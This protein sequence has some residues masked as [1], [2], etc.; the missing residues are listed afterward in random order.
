MI[1]SRLPPLNAL[2]AFEAVARNLS[3]IKAAREL[4][5]TPAAVSQHVKTLEADLGVKL[6]LR[7]EGGVELT[8][9]ARAALPM[10]RSALDKIFDASQCLRGRRLLPVLRLSV[11]PTFACLWLVP[12]L[13]SL[14]APLRE[15]ELHLDTTDE[16]LN[17]QR[18]EI[19]LDIH[20]GRG[21]RP[22]VQAFPL[23]DDRVFPVCSPRRLAAGPPLA[24]VDDL[25]HYELLHAGWAPLNENQ[26]PTQTWSDWLAGAGAAAVASDRGPRF[27]RIYIALQAAVHGLG[28]ALVS[29]ALVS[30]DLRAGRLVRPFEFEL[31]T[32]CTYYMIAPSRAAPPAEAVLLRDWLLDEAGAGR[33][34]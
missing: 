10:L 30:E 25:R 26:D 16:R 31:S 32:G 5:V 27:S 23:F 28:V 14:P 4:E 21:G 24:D 15:V 12:R 20:L 1:A 7:H 13:A 19:D 29:E 11:C 2:R 33:M 22:D 6:L 34:G 17:L 9:A 3:L 8:E 18:D